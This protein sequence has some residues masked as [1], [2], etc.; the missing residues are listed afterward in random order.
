VDIEDTNSNNLFGKK[1]LIANDGKREHYNVDALILCLRGSPFISFLGILLEKCPKKL[2]KFL[3]EW[4]S[5]LIVLTA[6]DEPLFQTKKRANNHPLKTK[7]TQ[8]KNYSKIIKKSLAQILIGIMIYLIIGWN[9]SNAGMKD[10]GPPKNLQF[11]LWLT[12]TDQ[13]W[14]MFSPHPPKSSWWY[15]IQGERVDAKKFELFR[16]GGLFT[17][18]GSDEISEDPPP[19]WISAFGNHRWFKFF[20][21][22]FNQ[23]NDYLRLSFGRY[24]CREYNKRHSGGEQVYTFQIYLVSHTVNLEGVKTRNGKSQLWSHQCF[25]KRPTY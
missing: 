3:D 6:D 16:H 23:N 20:E 1:W 7:F 10:Y 17:W 2:H 9:L 11:L 14:N 24:I 15:S 18:E 5:I 8:I 13:N 25:D 21:N 22:G 19:N 12:R 4:I